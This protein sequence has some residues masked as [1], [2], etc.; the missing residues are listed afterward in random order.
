[1]SN[2]Q[3]D[4]TFRT[5]VNAPLLTTVLKTLLMQGD[6]GANVLTVT[7]YSGAEAVDATGATVSGYLLR[8]DG[9]KVPLSGSVAGNVVTVKLDKHCYLVAGA[10]GAYVRLKM[11]DVTRTI[12]KIAGEIASEGDGPVVDIEEKLVSLEDIIAQMEEMVR[13]TEAAETATS[14]ANTAA[15]TASTAAGTATNAASTANGAAS[16]ANTA[17]ERAN[18]AAKALEEAPIP[19]GTVSSY[20]A[21]TSP[22]TPPAGTWQSTIPAVQQGQYLWTRT[23]Q[24]YTNG[25]PT[26]FYSV[27]RQGMDGSGSVASVDGVSPDAS[28]NV[29]LG[30]VRSV[31]GSVPDESGNVELGELGGGDVQTVCGKAPDENGNVALG[32]S[33]VGAR[34]STWMPNA[35][36]VGALPADGTAADSY[37]LGG[38]D[39]E[40]YAAYDNRADNSDFRQWVALA[41]VGGKH[42]TQSY[43]GD[44]WILDSGTITGVKNANGNGYSSITLNGTIRQVIANP[45]NTMTV[46]VGMVSGT[47]TTEYTYANGRGELT[48]TSA[49]GVLG[50]VMLLPGEWAA[51]PLY[52]PKGYSVELAE[53]Q[54]YYVNDD[55]IYVS[56]SSYGTGYI[57]CNVVFPVP[58]RWI[59]TVNIYSKGGTLGAVSFWDN[60]MDAHANVEV[61]RATLSLNGFNAITIPSNDLIEGKEYSFGYEASCEP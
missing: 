34:P 42:G 21:G 4:L 15:Q 32:A 30:A 61:N 8:E 10:F 54:S 35:S 3:M 51:Q 29:P 59:P 9:A 12:L 41:G 58:M 60:N 1:M 11:G 39:P 50:W 46:F 27:A 52:V 44:R 25:N 48:I 6:D 22:T 24:S 13:V 31:N 26:T 18:T 38:K 28:G 17:A 16:T 33:D 55:M 56:K 5:D 2:I 57:L 47:A 49:D 43:G 53:C 19:T 14:A 37:K 7:L 20:Q 45:E 23:V 40:Y 36:D